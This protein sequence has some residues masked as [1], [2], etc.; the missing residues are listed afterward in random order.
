MVAG[1]QACSIQRHKSTVGATAAIGFLTFDF[2]SVKWLK[3]RSRDMDNLK[4]VDDNFDSDFTILTTEY[5][6]HTFSPHTKKVKAEPCNYANKVKV[7]TAVH[8]VKDKVQ[9]FNA[10][11]HVTGMQSIGSS[12]FNLNTETQYNFKPDNPTALAEFALQESLGIPTRE[13]LEDLDKVQRNAFRKDVQG[14]EAITKFL[15]SVNGISKR[16]L[17]VLLFETEKYAA[18]AQAELFPGGRMQGSVIG[19]TK[20]PNTSS[21]TARKRRRENKN[22]KNL[23]IIK[24]KMGALIVT[25][26]LDQSSGCLKS[27]FR[28]AIKCHF[29]KD[30][31]TNKSYLID[32]VAVEFGIKIDSEGYCVPSYLS[33]KKDRN[34]AYDF[35]V[36]W[37][38]AYSIFMKGIKQIKLLQ[39]GGKKRFLERFNNYA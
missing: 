35:E 30:S 14:I 23:E 16:N 17:Y 10:H 4:E 33:N 3:K 15:E 28:K 39:Q 32:N 7:E 19:R 26:L 11:H 9:I 34:P 31:V 38:A 25:I 1:D 5:E 12:I 18:A 36:E 13:A 8:D 27:H 24:A 22:R 20:P 29:V 21:P 2:D 37:N 6:P